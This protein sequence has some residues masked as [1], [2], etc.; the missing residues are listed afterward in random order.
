LTQS[1]VAHSALV[2]IEKFDGMATPNDYAP[3]Q[4]A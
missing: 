1:P 2:Q 3:I 4:P